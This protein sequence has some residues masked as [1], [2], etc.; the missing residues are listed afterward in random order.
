[1]EHTKD[2]PKS[3]AKQIGK[4]VAYFRS[5]TVDE[6]G[7]PLSAVALADRCK[8]LGLDLGRVTIAKLENGLRQT[9]TVGEVQ[10]L[11]KALDV[12]PILLLF[13]LGVAET[14]EVLPGEHQGT[15]DAILWFTDSGDT[16]DVALF[17]AHRALVDAWPAGHAGPVPTAIRAATGVEEQRWRQ[18]VTVQQQLRQTRA[19]IRERGLTPPSLR[20]E[21]A[22]ID[23]QG[24][25]DGSR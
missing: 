12:A 17:T 22:W 21:L 1:M 4:R 13:P 24:T 9:I 11:A 15:L 18:A 10:V 19:F 16:S 5:Q 25:T 23:D 8:A 14:V 2:W 3:V 6:R 7:R 20:P